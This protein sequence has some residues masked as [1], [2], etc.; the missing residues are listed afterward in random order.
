MYSRSISSGPL[1]EH[2]TKRNSGAICHSRRATAVNRILGFCVSTETP[3][4]NRL[5]LASF[6]LKRAYTI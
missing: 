4:E 2:L 5:A 6:I 1:D 3:Y